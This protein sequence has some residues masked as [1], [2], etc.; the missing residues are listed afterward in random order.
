[1]NRYENIDEK[2]CEK[3]IK[4]LKRFGKRFVD[5]VVD[6]YIENFEYY[7]AGVALHDAI[8]DALLDELN[9]YEDEGSEGAYEYVDD[10]ALNIMD[11]DYKNIKDIQDEIDII[12]DDERKNR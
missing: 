1:M 10:T 5:T 6:K 7:D 3:I 8:C 11:G 9:F 4:S 12:I 2:E